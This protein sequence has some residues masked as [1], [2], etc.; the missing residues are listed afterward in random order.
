MYLKDVRGMTAAQIKALPPSWFHK[1]ERRYIQSPALIIPRLTDWYFFYRDLPDPA[2]NGR[3]FFAANHLQ[4][5]KKELKYVKQGYLSDKPGVQ[6]Y[7]KLPTPPG[8]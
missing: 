7:T 3:P 4:V 6:Y 5:F 2:K 8:T 1:H